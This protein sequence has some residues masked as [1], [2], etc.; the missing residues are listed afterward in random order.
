MTVYSKIKKKL[1]LKTCIGELETILE[2]MVEQVGVRGH[3]S[4]KI[5]Y[6]SLIMYKECNTKSSVSNQ[7]LTVS[8]LD[9]Y[10]W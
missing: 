10:D 5:K 8:E 6:S 7:F 2:T 9:L 4:C 1:N 3:D